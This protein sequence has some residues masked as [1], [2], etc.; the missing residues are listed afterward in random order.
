MVWLTTSS[1][2]VDTEVSSAELSSVRV[3]SVGLL[4]LESVW[5]ITVKLT[6]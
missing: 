5:S 3:I 4:A 2:E 6:V 1:R